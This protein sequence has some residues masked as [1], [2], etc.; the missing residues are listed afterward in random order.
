MS[1]FLGIEVHKTNKTLPM[2]TIF[3]VA[4]VSLDLAAFSTIALSLE[5]E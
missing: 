5:L 1:P 3:P 4:S 2:P